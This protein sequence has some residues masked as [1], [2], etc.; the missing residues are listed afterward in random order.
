M[1]LYLAT[2]LFIPTVNEI[3][4]H[5]EYLQTNANIIKEKVLCVQNIFVI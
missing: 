1:R 2:Q 3:S 5:Q 4:K